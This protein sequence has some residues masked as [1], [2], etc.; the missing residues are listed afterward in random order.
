M[1]INLLIIFNNKIKNKKLITSKINIFYENI[2]I[3]AIV[4]R[5]AFLIKVAVGRS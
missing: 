2:S 4:V 3:K 5:L 1:K